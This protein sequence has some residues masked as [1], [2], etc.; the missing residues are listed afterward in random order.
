LYVLGAQKAAT[1]SFEAEFREGKGIPRNH[2]YYFDGYFESEKEH[3]VFDYPQRVAA[4]RDEWSSHYRPCQQYVRR[5]AVDATPAYLTV[6]DAPTS[7]KNWYGFMANRIMFVVLLREP[8]KRMQSGFHY[9][10]GGRLNEIKMTGHDIAYDSPF[11]EPS[12]A[13]SFPQ[14]VKQLLEDPHARDES[15]CFQKSQYYTYLTHWFDTFDSHQF[16]IAPFLYQVARDSGDSSISSY[17]RSRL[18][19]HPSQC[20]VPRENSYWHPDLDSDLPPGSRLRI[21]IEDLLA[22][23]TGPHLLANLFARQPADLYNYTGSLTDE[24]SIALWLTDH[25]G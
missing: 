13:E 19:L 25:W 16:V 10:R 17:V 12:L 6:K 9:V 3:H 4:G 7:M 11:S 20:D 22:N 14:H 24:D 1:T 5:V 21:E 23:T 2:T 15:E 18:G 8:L